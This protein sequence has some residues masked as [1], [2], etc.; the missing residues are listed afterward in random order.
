MSRQ[1]RPAPGLP[2]SP[3]CQSV[4]TATKRLARIC[5]KYPEGCP[6]YIKPLAVGDPAREI[7]KLIDKEKVDPVVM[8][9]HG[10]KVNF[11]FGSV[12]QKVPKNAPAVTG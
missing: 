7:L 11:R 8:A 6:L 2:L 10:E 4:K 3:S 12:A 1:I 9:S 5:E